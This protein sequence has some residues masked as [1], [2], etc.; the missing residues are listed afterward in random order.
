[1]MRPGHGFQS[2]TDVQF[3][4]QP[5]N[6][7]SYGSDADMQ[8][9]RYRFGRQPVR[10]QTQYLLFPLRQQGNAWAIWHGIQMPIQFVWVFV[11]QLI[12]LNRSSG[13]CNSATA[14]HM[15]DHPLVSVSRGGQQ[16]A[17]IELDSFSTAAGDAHGKRGWRRPSRRQ[18]ADAA[19]G[20]AQRAACG[21]LA[22]HDV[23]TQATHGFCRRYTREIFAGTIPKSDTLI[24]VDGKHG[25]HR[26]ANQIL[27]VSHVC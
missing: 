3:C 8:V 2:A 27:K 22:F 1:M 16:G 26:A 23:M 19:P 21:I 18:F 24:R 9:T 4:H 10:Q 11:R 12:A 15:H 13:R 20:F 6:V 17:D 7:I 14:H 5:L 25:V